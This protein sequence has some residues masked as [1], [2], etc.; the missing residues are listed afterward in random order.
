MCKAIQHHQSLD[1]WL[2]ILR[3]C[4]RHGHTAAYAFRE[5]RDLRALIDAARAHPNVHA[6]VARPTPVGG[7]ADIAH[8]GRAELCVCQ[9]RSV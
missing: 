1:G 4:C 7:N 2:R 3:W 8:A 5:Q 9:R 6:H